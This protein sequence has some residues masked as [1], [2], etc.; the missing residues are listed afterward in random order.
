MNK[1]ASAL[2]LTTILTGCSLAPDFKIPDIQLPDVF[3][4]QVETP[5]ADDKDRKG[6]WQEAKPLE[7]QDRGQWWKV[8]GDE[9]LNDLEKQAQD[10][11]QSLKIAAARVLESRGL[12]ETY[13]PSI[14]PDLDIGGNA[15][16]T[17]PSSATLAAFGM[18]GNTK[19]KPYNMYSAQGTLSY[20]ADLFG[21]IRDNYRAYSLDAD[22]QDAAYK[23]ALL[24]LQ[25]DVAQQYFSIRA[26]D[27]ERQLL[28]DTLT[29]REEAARIMQRRF[30]V[31]AAGQQ[32]YTRTQSELSST[33]AELLSID[34]NRA[35]AEHALAVL[36]GKLPSEFAFAEAPLAS[37]P[38][39][40][41]PG[42]PSLLLE[43]RPDISSAAAS[44][45]AANRRIGVARAAFFPSLSLTALGGF[46]S[47]QLSDLFHWSSRTWAL[48][49]AAGS[50]LTMPIFDS[51][52]NLSRLDV[53]HAA[54]DEAVANYR[55][56]VLIAFRDVEDNLTNQ[57]MLAEQSQQQNKAAEASAQ[58]TKV[59]QIRYDAGDVDFFE[60]VNAQRD[61]LA[62][63]RAAVQL[64]GQRFLA[65]VGLIRAL[66][67]GWDEAASQPIAAPEVE[68]PK[69]PE[70]KIE[71]PETT[72][73]EVEEPTT[74]ALPPAELQPLIDAS[75]A[76]TLP[77]PQ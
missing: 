59:T 54:Y 10:A 51:G 18:P 57:K 36:L 53:S 45:E 17:Q 41:P 55:Q 20:E 67:G 11:N 19:L 40:I 24:S 2:L 12:A 77:V 21:S 16:R 46:Q 7:A 56:Q 50:A 72:D 13:S 68:A 1:I 63:G 48:G 75:P 61:S 65:T 71:E 35:N 39:A 52:R 37:I 74:E 4:E 25:A 58:T 22:A 23:S 69:A 33:K 3:K 44:M 5:K 60:V 14:L 42:I 70:V 47:T 62:A 27:S 15:V 28:R 49:Q 73:F 66:G 26:L 8:F 64:R 9:Q 43:R 76:G 34:R 38:P 6:L 32:D 31:G 29:I 30:D